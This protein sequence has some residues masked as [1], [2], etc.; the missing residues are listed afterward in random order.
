VRR[1]GFIVVA[2]VA[3]GLIAG[4]VLF[5]RGEAD[6]AART[7][8]EAKRIA[9]T[10]C[11]T[12]FGEMSSILRDSRRSQARRLTPE[13]KAFYE[14]RLRRLRPENCEKAVERELLRRPRKR[15]SARGKRRGGDAQPGGNAKQPP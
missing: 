15:Q 8:A 1:V 9:I 2:L 10:A 5:N 3:I 14:R 4:N 6:D 12:A 11:Q 7:A 13:G